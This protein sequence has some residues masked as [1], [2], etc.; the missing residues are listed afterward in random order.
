MIHAVSGAKW[1][2]AFLGILLAGLTGA[3]VVIFSVPFVVGV[4]GDLWRNLGPA[5][6]LAV[7]ACAALMRW[8]RAW[9]RAPS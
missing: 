3:V 5:P 9:R 2:G 7:V 4:G 1:A 8:R 6:L